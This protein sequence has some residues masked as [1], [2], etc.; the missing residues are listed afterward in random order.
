[1]TNQVW[2]TSAAPPVDPLHDDVTTTGP[3]DPRDGEPVFT[4]ELHE[5]RLFLH[6]RRQAG[7]VL[8]GRVGPVAA[9]HEVVAERVDVGA[10]TD[11]HAGPVLRLLA[12]PVSVARE[13][14]SMPVANSAV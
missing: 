3:L 4:G 13:E 8:G 6:P 7:V 14:A 5:R 12:H 11:A 9:Q 10:A 2:A 1:M